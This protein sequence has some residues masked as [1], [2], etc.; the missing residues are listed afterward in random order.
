[1]EGQKRQDKQTFCVMA[2]RK[3]PM[4]FIVTVSTLTIQQGR[5]DNKWAENNR[6]EKEE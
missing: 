3:N 2:G 6:A 4:L 5:W 1:M